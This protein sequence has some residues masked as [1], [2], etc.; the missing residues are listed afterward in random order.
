MAIKVFT[1]VDFIRR[2]P[3]DDL[4]I[5]Y[6]HISPIILAFGFFRFRKFDL[7]ILNSLRLTTYLFMIV[8]LLKVTNGKMVVLDPVF[9]KPCGVIQGMV[10]RVKG[11]LLNRADAIYVYSKNNSGVETYFGI[12]NEKFIYIPFKVNG[13]DLINKKYSNRKYQGYVFS[14]GRS[15]RDYHTLIKAAATLPEI[16]FKIVCPGSSELRRENCRIFEGELP[17]NVTIINDHGTLEEFLEIMS[18]SEIVVL[19][20]I[21][22]NIAPAGIS[23]YLNSMALRRPVIITEG[24]AVDDIL[25]EDQAVIVKVDDVNDLRAKIKELYYDEERKKEMAENAYQY[26]MSLGD[27]KKLFKSIEQLVIEL[28]K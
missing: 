17:S 20:T 13:L 21:P 16:P 12:K 9:V 27:E 25:T 3:S 28:I 8:S 26:A 6:F 2:Y 19:T 18:E 4:D 10:A 22:D 1:D 14:G 7:F 23:V 5:N 15:R 11:F 24:P